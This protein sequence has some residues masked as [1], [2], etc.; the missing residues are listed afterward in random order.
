MSAKNRTEA[1][2]EMH[3]RAK[4]TVRQVR[5]KGG[6]PQVQLDITSKLA[7]QDYADLASLTSKGDGKQPLI[8]WIVIGLSHGPLFD[9]PATSAPTSAPTSKPVKAKRGARGKK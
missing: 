3:I 8:V 2:D 6:V 5:I 1:P 9:P 7:G 4:A